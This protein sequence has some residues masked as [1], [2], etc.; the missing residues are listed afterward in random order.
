MN[1]TI[2]AIAAIDHDHGKIIIATGIRQK[3]ERIYVSVSDN[4]RGIDP[5]ISDKIFDPFFT[6]RQEEG[7]TGLGLSV[8]HNL[9]KVH[10]GEITFESEK[11]KGTT[12][13]IKLPVS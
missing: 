5:F 13:T 12:F 1:L 7:G 6:T 3:E 8:T 10:D 2:N 4:G 11:G 9:V